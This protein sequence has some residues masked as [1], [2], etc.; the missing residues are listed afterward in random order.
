MANYHQISLKETF[1]DCQDNF[2]EN[3]LFF[4]RLLNEHIDLSDFIPLILRNVF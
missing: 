3:M 2:Q 4:F 1:S